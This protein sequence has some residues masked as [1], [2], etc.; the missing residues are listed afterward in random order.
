MLTPTVYVSRARSLCSVLV[1]TLLAGSFAGCGT[2]TGPQ[3]PGQSAAATGAYKV[4]LTDAEQRLRANER[5]FND[6]VTGAVLRN[7][8]IGAGIGAATAL[9]SGRRGQ[10]VVAGAAIGAAAGGALGAYQ[11]Y[12]RAKLEQQKM[13]IAAT[14]NS[15]ADDIQQQNARWASDL[16]DARAVH[17]TSMNELQSL[18]ARARAGTVQVAEQRA[19]IAR[20]EENHKLMQSRLEVMRK[21]QGQYEEALAKLPRDAEA[22]RAR[23]EQQL[24][25]MRNSVGQLQAHVASLGNALATSRV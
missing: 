1:L 20:I 8:M 2:P 7:A 4:A 6:V 21:E 12:T 11:G 10:D 18:Q 16:G 24:A 9:L 5:R 25:V 22:E 23:A 13:N 19:Q 3:I 15:I 14:Y 17:A